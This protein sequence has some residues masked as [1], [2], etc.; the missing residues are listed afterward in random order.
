MSDALDGGKPVS[1]CD[2]LFFSRDARKRADD[3]GDFRIAGLLQVA[4]E[5]QQLTTVISSPIGDT[6]AVD[7]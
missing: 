6:R 7:S 4:F 1:G 5:K 3:V 2:L